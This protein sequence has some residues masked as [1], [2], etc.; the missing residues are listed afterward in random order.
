MK[1]P[2]AQIDARKAPAL[3]SKQAYTQKPRGQIH[4]RSRQGRQHL[5]HMSN[6]MAGRQAHFCPHAGKTQPG[7]LPAQGQD[8][9]DMAQFMNG[10]GQHGEQKQALIVKVIEQRTQKQ[11]AAAHLY[12]L[13]A[14]HGH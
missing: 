2:R 5:A 3:L 14:Q 10:T 13:P 11:R 4:Q 8:S 7:H 12:S 1:A 9:Q 6:G